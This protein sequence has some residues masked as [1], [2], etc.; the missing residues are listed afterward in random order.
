[1]DFY[2]GKTIEEILV[3]GLK[4]RREAAALLYFTLTVASLVLTLLAWAVDR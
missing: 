4:S 2:L 3:G 1:M